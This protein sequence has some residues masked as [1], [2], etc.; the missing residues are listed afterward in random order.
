[1]LKLLP[2]LTVEEK[3]CQ[4]ALSIIEESV[5]NQFSAIRPVRKTARAV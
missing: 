3:V 4:R 1:V 5:A 2:P